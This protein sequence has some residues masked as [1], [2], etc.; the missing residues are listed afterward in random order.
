MRWFL[1]FTVAGV[2]LNKHFALSHRVLPASGRNHPAD[3]AGGAAPWEIRPLHH[4][5]RHLQHLRH[6]PCPQHPLPLTRDS[7]GVIPLTLRFMHGPS[8]DGAVGE[9][10]LHPHSASPAQHQATLF[11][12]GQAQVCRILEQVPFT[13]TRLTVIS[14]FHWNILEVFWSVSC[15]I[16]AAVPA[17]FLY[18]RISCLFA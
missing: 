1:Y 9:E 6:R 15:P 4:D 16:P 3:L 11:W 13:P 7:Q 2:P 8:S 18:Y 17:C 12:Q 10:G 5:P 14:T